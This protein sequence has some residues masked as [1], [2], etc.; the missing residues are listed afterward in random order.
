M[1][2]QIE[3]QAGVESVEVDRR[4][5]FLRVDARGPEDVAAVIARLHEL[6]FAAGRTTDSA[7]E[8]QWYRHDE[9]GELSRE[10]AAVIAQRVVPAFARANDLP[11]RADTL[12]DL[13]A[14]DLASVLRH[15][16]GARGL[17]ARNASRRMRARRRAGNAR[18]LGAA[19][20]SELGKAIEADLAAGRSNKPGSCRG[21]GRAYA[22]CRAPRWEFARVT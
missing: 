18:S 13:V 20:A 11:D 7:A 12:T 14:I 9:V 6:G 17:A 15:Q 2:A 3:Q 5:E 8:R 16:R 19:R 22:P 10:E 4:G 21:I 1:L